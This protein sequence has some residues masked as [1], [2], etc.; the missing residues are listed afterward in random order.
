LFLQEEQTTIH[1]P[2][3]KTNEGATR[4]PLNIWNL[5]VGLACPAPEE[6]VLPT[7]TKVQLGVL[8]N[9]GM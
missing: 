1:K 7:F 9:I 2:L 6:C 3:Q 8:K 5:L 4:T